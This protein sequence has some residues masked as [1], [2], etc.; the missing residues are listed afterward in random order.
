MNIIRGQ[1]YRHYSGDEYEVDCIC[2]NTDNNERYVVYH[3]LR[4]PDVSWATLYRQFCNEINKPLNSLRYDQ[5]T[6]LKL[7]KDA[8]S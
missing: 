5:N 7:I 3:E 6:H 4:N 2:V 1:V 8:E